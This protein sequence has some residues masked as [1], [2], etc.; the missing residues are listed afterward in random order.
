MSAPPAGFD[1]R[2][3]LGEPEDDDLA[4]VEIDET[5][6]RLALNGWF[7]TLEPAPL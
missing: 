5:Q 2:S 4:L 1:P 3:R 6:V 7:N